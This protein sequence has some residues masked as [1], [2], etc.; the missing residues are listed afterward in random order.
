V[1]VIDTC[2]IID[3]TIHIK[4]FIEGSHMKVIIPI[5]FDPDPP[6]NVIALRQ[7]RYIA[8]VKVVVRYRIGQAG[9]IER[10]AA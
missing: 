5:S 9:N 6:P 7:P 8:T 4:K 1:Y 3:Y 2:V 10:I